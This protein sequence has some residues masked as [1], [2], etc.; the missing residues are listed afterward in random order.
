M[1]NAIHRDAEITTMRCLGYTFAVIG[2]KFNISTQRAH[3]IYNAEPK[4][5]KS[6]YL[7]IEWNGEIKWLR[8]RD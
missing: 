1:D 7:Q 4:I 3:Q 8:I 2:E 5:N 6:K